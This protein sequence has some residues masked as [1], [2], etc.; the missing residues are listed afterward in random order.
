MEIILGIGCLM[1]AAL[2]I[3]YIATNGC[4]HSY[5]YS[6]TARDQD[7]MT[8]YHVYTCKKCG[9]VLKSNNKL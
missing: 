6:Y 3:M 2:I 1:I 4:L 9:K 8:M 5:E 7:Q